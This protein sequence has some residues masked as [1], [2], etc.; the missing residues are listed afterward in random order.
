M[1]KIVILETWMISHPRNSLIPAELSSNSYH[2]ILLTKKCLTLP[3][4]ITQEMPNNNNNSNK[5]Y[6]YYHYPEKTLLLAKTVKIPCLRK[7]TGIS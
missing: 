4:D 5:I 7:K 6:Y 2:V 1:E 3:N